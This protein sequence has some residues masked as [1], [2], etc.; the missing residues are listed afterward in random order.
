MPWLFDLGFF[1]DN[2]LANDRIK[3]LD[4]HFVRHGSLVLARG[5][6]VPG[7]RR[8]YQF[9]LFSHGLD[10]LSTGAKITNDLFNTQLVNNPHA[11]G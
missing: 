5:V 8:R 4:L 11:F 6:V 10:L 9:D 2:M 1:V 7:S 3:F